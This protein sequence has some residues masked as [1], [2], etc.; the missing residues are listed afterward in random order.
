NTELPWYLLQYDS[1]LG[2]QTCVSKLNFLLRE[3]PARYEKQF[4]VDGFEWVD[5]NHREEAV[6]AY[7]RKGHNPEE[8]ILVMLN[9][10]PTVRRDWKLKIRGKMK[11]KEIF[12]SDL[13]EFGGTGDVFNPD[14]QYH[15][16]EDEEK[17]YEI[18]VHL[19]PLA[20]IV[21]I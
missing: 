19:P 20:G 10:T 6:V 15:I 18:I 7:M 16:I 13:K 9:M 17:T 14:I 1:H 5:L 8:N 3:N 11:W 4:S 12:N 2:I 21:L